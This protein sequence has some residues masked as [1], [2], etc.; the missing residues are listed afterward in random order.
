MAVTGDVGTGGA[1]AEKA[2]PEDKSI[3]AGIGIYEQRV[4]T[5]AHLPHHGYAPPFEEETSFNVST[6][7]AGAT[8]PS[9]CPSTPKKQR[10]MEQ[11]SRDDRSPVGVIAYIHRQLQRLTPESRYER[12]HGKRPPLLADGS[13]DPGFDPWPPGAWEGDVMQWDIAEQ[14][15]QDTS[16]NYETNQGYK[17]WKEWKLRA[18]ARETAKKDK[19]AKVAW[20][21]AHQ[22]DKAQEQG[23]PYSGATGVFAAGETSHST[24]RENQQEAEEW[25][26]CYRSGEAGCDGSTRETTA[27]GHVER[28][29]THFYDIDESESYRVSRQETEEVQMRKQ[30]GEGKELGNRD[31]GKGGA[32]DAMIADWNERSRVG[33]LTEV[34]TIAALMR[35]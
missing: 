21:A 17:A 16:D 25:A 2:K 31:P 15:F 26:Q 19:K 1:A 29:V 6:A 11:C 22:Q 4:A 23:A 33:E 9:S 10:Q 18:I 3:K 7:E 27:K 24:I 28:G 14:L 8:S 34:D 12:Y 35:R 20:M 32:M 13:M 5:E 30:T